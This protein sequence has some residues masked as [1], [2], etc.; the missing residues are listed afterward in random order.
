MA[1]SGNK[2]KLIELSSDINFLTVN[3]LADMIESLLY[4]PKVFVV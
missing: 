3:T 2:I 1:G 4:T